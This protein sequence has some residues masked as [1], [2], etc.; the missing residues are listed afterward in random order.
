MKN[1]RTWPS[2]KDTRRQEAKERQDKHD[3]LTTQQK[4]SKLDSYGRAALKERNKLSK[5][6][7]KN[8]V[9]K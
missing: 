6:Y 4:I 5:E 1:G 8:K 7:V 9:D 2:G 3:K